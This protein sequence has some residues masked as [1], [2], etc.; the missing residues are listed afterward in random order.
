MS[1][2]N[3]QTVID[4]ESAKYYAQTISSIGQST[5]KALNTRFAKAQAIKKANLKGQADLVKFSSDYLKDVNKSLKDF[6]KAHGSGHF[7]LN[8]SMKISLVQP[9]VRQGGS[10]FSGY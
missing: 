6:S 9:N 5:V 4:T 7:L 3:P 2:R 1:Y 8:S 10:A